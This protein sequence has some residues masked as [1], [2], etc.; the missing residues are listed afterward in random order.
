MNAQITFESGLL[1]I[2]GIFSYQP[3]S[4]IDLFIKHGYESMALIQ[5]PKDISSVEKKSRIS[6]TKEFYKN[7]YYR[8]FHGFLLSGDPGV[9]YSGNER[10][11]VKTLRKEVNKTIGFL[12][13]DP[14]IKGMKSISTTIEHCEIY[15]FPD[16]IGMFSM[17][18]TPQDWQATTVSDTLFLARNFSSKI[19]DEEEYEFHQWISKNLLANIKLT[20]D[21]IQSDEFSGSKFKTYAILNLNESA[22]SQ[23]YN[24]DHLLYEIGTCSKLDSISDKGFDA[25]SEDYLNSIMSDK[26]A[27]FNNYTGLALMDSFT[28]IGQGHYKRFEEDVLNHHNWSRVYFGIYIFNL[29]IRFNLFKFNTEYVKNPVRYRDLFQE[30]INQYNFRHISFNFLPNILF[31]AM[32]KSL[33]IDEEIEHFESRLQGLAAQLQEEQEKRQALL[34]TLISVLSAFDAVDGIVTKVNEIKEMSGL[35]TVPFFVLAGLTGLAL[36]IGISYYLFP[37]HFNKAVKALKKMLK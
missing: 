21:N 27:I 28:L 24:R 9:D 23:E 17:T 35:S 15:L 12:K 18:L 5:L 30:F 8:E 26:I 7:V 14:Q 31:S 16:K 1:K 6:K 11:T 13:Y 3:K 22:L 4:H 19:V 29:Y 33:L 20:G 36:L 10:K 34:L 37:Y 2:T 25:P 32:R